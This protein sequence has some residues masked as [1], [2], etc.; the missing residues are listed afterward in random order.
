MQPRNAMNGPRLFSCVNNINDRDGFLHVET[1]VVVENYAILE[2]NL[3]R[4]EGIWI[5]QKF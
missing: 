3:D 2:D 5:F 4:E 1:K